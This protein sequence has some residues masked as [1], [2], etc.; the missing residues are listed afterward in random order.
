MGPAAPAGTQCA[1][2]GRAPWSPML[3]MEPSNAD[4][5]D[6]PDPPRY[7]TPVISLQ[8]WSRSE[9]S[10]FVGGIAESTWGPCVSRDPKESLFEVDRWRPVFKGFARAQHRTLSTRAAYG[11]SGLNEVGYAKPVPLKEQCSRNM[12]TTMPVFLITPAP[13]NSAKEK[14]AD[15]SCGAFP[16]A[17]PL[18]QNVSRPVLGLNPT[19]VPTISAK[20]AAKKW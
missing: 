9:V 15:P 1:S 20:K 4:G 3:A 5:R 2:G 8:W 14:Q 10:M 7:K 6:H 17:S 16:V 12:E 18:G 13:G 19:L 11:S